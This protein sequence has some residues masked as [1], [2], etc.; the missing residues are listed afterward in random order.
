MTIRSPLA[1]I[2][3]TQI[4][5]ASIAIS[6]LPGQTAPS[7]TPSAQKPDPFGAQGPDI[8]WQVQVSRNEEALQKQSD[9]IRAQL[10]RLI[11]LRI[12]EETTIGDFVEM[13]QV[14]QRDERLNVLVA[15]DLRNIRLPSFD[16]R[17][18]RVSSA[19]QILPR[20]AGN[21]AITVEI[22]SATE[23]QTADLISISIDPGFLPSVGVQTHPIKRIL[24]TIKPESLLQTLE[25][26]IQFSDVGSP[27]VQIA[28]EAETG[29]LFVKGTTAQLDVVSEILQAIQV[30]NIPVIG[31]MGGGMGGMGSMGSMGGFVP[32]GVPPAGLPQADPVPKSGDAPVQNGGNF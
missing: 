31:G 18:I 26:G 32:G 27:K 28:L 25:K 2:A 29:L 23:N 1:L 7:P 13:I 4:L 3:L 19:F 6:S 9:K 17:Q 10:G 5:F 15:E 22:E 16:L 21:E 11:D 12:E 8:N 24:D 14:A 20:L 30:N